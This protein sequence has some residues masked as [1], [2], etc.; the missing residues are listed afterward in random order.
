MNKP[1]KETV[2]IFSKPNS[3]PKRLNRILKKP[4]S[5][6]SLRDPIFRKTLPKLLN[7]NSATN[8]PWNYQCKE[9]ET[10]S[11]D[12]IVSIFLLFICNLRPFMSTIQL[13]IDL[14]D[15]LLYTSDAADDMQC[16]D[17]GGRRIIKKL[18]SGTS[19]RRHATTTIRLFFF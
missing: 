10:K 2:S 13:Q 9:S 8:P 3:E 6:N 4:S 15:C 19:G 17:L 16:V 7:P 5:R 12:S 14:I 18:C 11:S 1:W